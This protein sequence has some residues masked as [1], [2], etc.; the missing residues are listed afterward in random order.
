M[1]CIENI[2][3]VRRK[4]KR[5]SA[6]V[7]IEISVGLGALL[8]VA[9]L[10]MRHSIN[11]ATMDRWTV[12]QS[13]TDTYMTRE[14]AMAKRYPFSEF[15]GGSSL[16][17]TFPNTAQSTVEVGRLPGGEPVMA[18]LYRTKKPSDNNMSSAGGSGTDAT[19]PT[20]T[21]AWVLQSYLTHEIGDRSYLKSRS[22]VRSQ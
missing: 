3:N 19:N 21:E 15:T 16:W 5:Q 7:L 9:I 4:R 18:T 14:V 8:I 2:S 22:V 20:N 13:L 17:P 11:V 6:M 1:T 10:L 12:M